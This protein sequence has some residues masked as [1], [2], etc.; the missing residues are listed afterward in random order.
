MVNLN[1]KAHSMRN[2]LTI[3]LG[4]GVP[5]VPVALVDDPYYVQHPLVYLFQFPTTC[6]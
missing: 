4:T 2:L 6:A 1:L 3:S 5:Y